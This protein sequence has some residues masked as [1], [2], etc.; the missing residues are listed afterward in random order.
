M[1]VRTH[2]APV[3]SLMF[4]LLLARELYPYVEPFN[5]EVIEGYTLEKIAT[6]FGGPTCLEWVDEEHL[7]LCD[8]DEGRILSLNASDEF[9]ATTL[10]SGLSHPHGF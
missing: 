5:S 10:L 6:G 9:A 4:F 1:G 8:R 3:V 2:L 7:I